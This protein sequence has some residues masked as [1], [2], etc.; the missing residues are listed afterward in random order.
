MLNCPQS[1]L[2]HSVRWKEVVQR[3]FP[4]TALYLIVR[5]ESDRIVGLL[6]G[7]VI[8]LR[9]FRIYNSLPYSDYGGP[10]ALSSCSIEALISLSQFLGDLCSQENIAYSK[11]LL[12]SELA[13]HFRSRSSYSD[14]SKGVM[15]I[16]L[17]TATSD[18]IWNK[19][20]SKYRRRDF[21]RLERDGFQAQ[22]AR[23]TSDLEDFYN[24]YLQNMTYIGAH[25]HTLE[26]MRNLWR[27]LYPHNLRIWLVGKEKR[28]G[29]V[30]ILKYG[31]KEYGIYVGLDR[32]KRYS[33]YP[34]VPYLVWRE[35]ETAE[36]EN[37]KSISLGA[38][39]GDFRNP[40]YTQK[41]SLGAL[42]VQQETSYTPYDSF[43]HMLL[44][45]KFK[46]VYV[47]RAVK[48]Y[49]PPKLRTTLESRLS[50]L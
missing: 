12:G 22:E 50:T 33:K 16:N 3:S 18:F 46:T 34:F 32:D 49:L 5:D 27:I 30:A 20:F 26:F 36:Q 39:S 43:G 21:R 42:F 45:S 28:I 9:R 7:F 13:E 6:P 31:Q 17:E 37:C 38:T 1:T 41:R 48:N 47:W 4:Y 35:I 15:E 25:P 44:Q 40:Y 23:T 10:L 2:F 29:G 24:L 19:V 8:G 11:I 14:R